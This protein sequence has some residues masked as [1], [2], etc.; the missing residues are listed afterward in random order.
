M[1]SAVAPLTGREKYLPYITWCY[2]LL[3]ILVAYRHFPIGSPDFGDED[4]YAAEASYLSQYG[5]A[6]ALSQ[7]TSFVLS[8]LIYLTS[9]I[10]F[11]DFLTGGRILSIIC[12]ASACKLFHK[13]LQRFTGL[14]ASE[15]YFGVIGMATICIG[16]LWKALADIPSMCFIL[17]A[18]CLLISATRQWQTLLA[19]IVLFL[20]FAVK[21]T[22]VFT[23]PGFLFFTVLYRRK[24]RPFSSRAIKTIVFMTGF[25]ASFLIY[26]VPGYRTYHKLMLESKDHHYVG[27]QRVE[28][29]NLW[30][31]RN[32]YFEAY[33]PN[34]HPNKWA[35][36]W[37]EIDTFK[38]Q[39]PDIKLNLGYTE[40]AKAHTGIWAKNIAGKIFLYLPYSIQSEFFFAK[41]TVANRWLKNMVLLQLLT[42]LLVTAICIH[43]RRFIKEN[44][45]LL[46]VPF[47]YFA[48]LCTYLIPQLEDNWLLFCIPFL[49]LPVVKFLVRYVNIY[50]LVGL[51]IIYILI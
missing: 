21:P 37:G 2:I 48:I 8:L 13:C 23:I 31:E 46:L 9:K 29:P 11:T 12:F 22:V 15:Q 36:T 10:F 1:R 39:H 43:Q 27:K 5:F 17:G 47:M 14:S 35:V 34:H 32:I 25:I 51:Q 28:N 33:N 3:V 26:H 30:N 20:G 41:W 49:A 38:Q 40:Y 50:V 16:W 18:F 44:A 4:Y 45:V 19:G 42:L 7:G 6:A 24:S